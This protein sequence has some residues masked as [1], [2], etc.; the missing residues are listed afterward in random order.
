MKAA[1]KAVKKVACGGD[2]RGGAGCWCWTKAA[3]WAANQ[4]QQRYGQQR[5]FRNGEGVSARRAHAAVA[6]GVAAG[7]E[8]P[9]AE[10]M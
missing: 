3:C 9:E 5:R 1:M 10:G 2:H 7:V 6:A 4:Q 8:L